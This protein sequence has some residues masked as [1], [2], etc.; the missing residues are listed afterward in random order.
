MTARISVALCSYNGSGFIP[1]QLESILEQTSAADEIVLSDDGS[2]DGT[3]EVAE[4]VLAH[5]AGTRRVL[6]NA[7]ALGVTANFEQAIRA[8]TGDLIVLSDQDDVWHADRIERALAEFDSRPDLTFLFTDARMVDSEGEPLGYSLFDAL[9]ISDDDRRLIHAGRAFEVLLRRNLATGATVMFRRSVLEAA[10][11]F[12]GGWV[13]DE[14]VAII[15]AATGRVDMLEEQLIDYRQHGNNQIGMR[16]PGLRQK[17]RRVLQPRGNRNI[18]LAERTRVL[19]D[20]LAELGDLVD[21]AALTSARGKLRIERSRAALPANRLAR[22]VPVLR[23]ARSGDYERY[24]SQGR[25]EILRD[26]F[27]PR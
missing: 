24:T 8:T 4:I 23:E 17:V 16:E 2:T 21:R 18:E 26:L 1:E 6:R 5:A 12:P 14:W 25:R 15:A 9:E 19:V 3:L 13:H 10:L 7:H 20:R 11:P 27:Q 22:I